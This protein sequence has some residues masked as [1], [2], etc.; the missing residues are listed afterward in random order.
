MPYFAYMK[1]ERRRAPRIPVSAHLEQHIEGQSH[2]CFMSDL[3][4]TGLYMERPISSFV[5]HS[6]KV[7]L[8]IALPDGEGEPLWATAEIV[9]DCFDSTFHGTAVRFED[10]G[11]RDRRRLSAFLSCRSV[12]SSRDSASAA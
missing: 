3:S 6:T 4:L 5:R 12:E 10:M 7:Q 11:D 9:Y 2:R 1:D 8:E